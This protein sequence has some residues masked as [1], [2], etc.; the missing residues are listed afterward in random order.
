MRVVGRFDGAFSG[1]G[2]DLVMQ[3]RDLEAKFASLPPDQEK[4][5][6]TQ[7]KRLGFN[8]MEVQTVDVNH[9]TILCTMIY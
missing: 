8:D 7:L 6:R 5:L 4:K 9:Q 3:E 1:S 2:F